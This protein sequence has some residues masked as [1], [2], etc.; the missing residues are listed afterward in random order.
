MSLHAMPLREAEGIRYEMPISMRNSTAA[1]QFGGYKE[2]PGDSGYSISNIFFES[3]RIAA[4][5]DGHRQ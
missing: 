1:V 4:V 2:Q 3:S 5:C